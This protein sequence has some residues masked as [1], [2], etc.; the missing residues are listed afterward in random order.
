MWSEDLPCGERMC[1]GGL[2]LVPEGLQPQ[3]PGA[4]GQTRP[5]SRAVAVPEI[6]LFDEET[7][8]ALVGREHQGVG[9]QAGEEGFILGEEMHASLAWVW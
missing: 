4:A 8:E 5:G 6:V 3:A 9:V 2:R 7:G 1:G